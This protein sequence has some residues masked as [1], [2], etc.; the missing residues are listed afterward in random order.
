M[1]E[2]NTVKFTVGNVFECRSVCDHNCVWTFLVTKRT[3]KTITICEMRDGKLTGTGPAM[4]RIQVHANVETVFP[5]GRYSMAP[6]LA[7]DKKVAN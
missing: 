4:A 1:S 3:P 5:L 2:S 6:I 7:A